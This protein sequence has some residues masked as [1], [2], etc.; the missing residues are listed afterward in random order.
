MA[1]RKRSVLRTTGN[2]LNGTADLVSGTVR[3][4]LFGV[5]AV[6]AVAKVGWDEAKRGYTQTD[7]LLSSADQTQDQAPEQQEL[8]LTEQYQKFTGRSS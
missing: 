6:A 8:D 7:E 4:G 1:N 2:I 3:W 5:G